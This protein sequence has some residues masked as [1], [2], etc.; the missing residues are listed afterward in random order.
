VTP[1]LRVDNNFR[2]FMYNGDLI[3][4]YKFDDT[5]LYEIKWYKKGN[6]EDRPPSRECKK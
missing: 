2:I 3:N 1:K 4:T 5:E 6:F